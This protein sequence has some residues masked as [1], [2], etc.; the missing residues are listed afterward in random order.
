VRKQIFLLDSYTSHGHTVDEVSTYLFD[1]YMG[2]IRGNKEEID[3]IVSPTKGV[4]SFNKPAKASAYE[5]LKYILNNKDKYAAYLF[6]IYSTSDSNGAVIGFSA[7]QDKVKL[8]ICGL[9][10]ACNIEKKKKLQL[11]K[12]HDLEEI[13]NIVHSQDDARKIVNRYIEGEKEL[14]GK[15]EEIFNISILEAS[16]SEDTYQAFVDVLTQKE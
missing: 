10:D 13:Y 11:I 1:K 12:E 5:E 7:Y 9:I 3:L 2:E 4:V 16:L 6:K 8:T 15:I 14:I